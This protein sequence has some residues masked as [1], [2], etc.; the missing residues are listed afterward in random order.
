MLAL[1]IQVAGGRDSGV[2]TLGVDA[3][4][5]AASARRDQKAFSTLVARHYPV[6]YRVVWRLMNGHSDAEDVTQEAFLRLWNNPTQLREA[7]ALRGWLIRVA[8]NLVTDRFRRSPKMNSTG[9]DEI[10]DNRM[11][12]PDAIDRQHVSRK[13][14]AALATL[15][16]RQKLALTLVQFEQLSNAAAADVLEISVDALE[17]LLSRARRGLKEQLAGE[18]QMMLA[19]LADER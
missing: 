10:V 13:I 8:S 1:A 4:L 14:D 16:E 6:V 17:S 18:W 19:T 7:G 5:L 9:T 12:A 11:A 2:D 3:S 15:P